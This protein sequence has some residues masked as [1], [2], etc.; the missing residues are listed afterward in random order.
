M[1][2]IVKAILFVFAFCCTICFFVGDYNV[3]QEVG[4]NR[5]RE[6]AQ[7]QG[8]AAE[9]I[10][11]KQKEPSNFSVTFF[12]VGQAEAALVECEG[13]Y[14]LVDGGN[15]DDSDLIYTVLKNKNITNLDL[16]VATH[17]HEDHVGGLSGALNYATA[18]V[19]LCSVNEY[20]T[21]V[22]EN[23]KKYAE[24]NGGGIKVPSVGD[25]YELGSAI[26]EILGVGASESD[27]DSSIILKITYGETAFLFTGDAE[28]AA[29][30]AVLDAKADLAAT[31]LS[32][33]H[34]GSGT[35]TIYP[36]LREVMPE[37]AVISVGAE[38]EYGHPM[39]SVLSRLRDADAQVYRTD[40][41][42]DIVCTSDGVTVTVETERE[43]DYEAIMTPGI[44]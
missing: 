6:N 35:S 12:D 29:E 42:G 11:D 43:A 30:Q 38:N 18:D 9:S 44:F 34:H 39:D 10:S 5:E 37:I 27:N 23:F 1:I 20:D 24:Q 17:E 28:R 8:S 21:R 19:V 33:S 14:M 32:V 7:V 2:K 40:L 3:L 36:F 13:H 4:V 16:I 25:S 26:V 31:V 22:F 41:H 15:A